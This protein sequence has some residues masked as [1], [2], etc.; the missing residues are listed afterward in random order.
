[1]IDEIVVMAKAEALVICG[2]NK[3]S[4]LLVKNHLAAGLGGAH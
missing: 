4:A 2:E 1:M 3:G